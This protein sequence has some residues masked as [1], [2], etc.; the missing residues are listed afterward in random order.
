MFLEKVETLVVEV[1]CAIDLYEKVCN[2]H[3]H[4]NQRQT[5]LREVN[6]LRIA[7]RLVHSLGILV[8]ALLLLCAT[9]AMCSVIAILLIK[10][11]STHFHISCSLFVLLLSFIQGNCEYH[12]QR[13]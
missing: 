12:F 7:K 8:N 11:A 9:V 4:C 10:I 3:D 13:H 5:A 6:D 2:D 1:S